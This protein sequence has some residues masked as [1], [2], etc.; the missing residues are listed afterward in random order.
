MGIFTQNANMVPS[1]GRRL[2][3]RIFYTLQQKN[4]QLLSQAKRKQKGTLSILAMENEKIT[5]QV[6]HLPYIQ[7]TQV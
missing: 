3:L 1:K 2:E 5:Q 7:L 6:G 4:K